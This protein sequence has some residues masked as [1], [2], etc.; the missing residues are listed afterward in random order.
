MRP[1]WLRIGA[2]A[3]TLVVV[4]L[5]AIALLLTYG[6]PDVRVAWAI[7]AVIALPAAIGAAALVEHRQTSRLDSIAHN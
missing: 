1:T 4:G 3:V 7:A 6:G 2:A 5:V